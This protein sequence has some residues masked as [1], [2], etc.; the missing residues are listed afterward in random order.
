MSQIVEFETLPGARYQQYVFKLRAL[1]GFLGGPTGT[2]FKKLRDFMRQNGI[3]DKERSA[4]AM[5][6]LE[7]TWDRKTVTLGPTAKRLLDAASEEDFKE[8]LFKRLKLTNILLVKYVLE[9]LDV[10]SGG[11]LHSVNEL[12]RMITSYVYPGEYVTLTN[13][14]AWIE[15]MAASEVIKM[16]GIRWALGDPRGTSAVEELK[17]MDIEE[18]LEDLEEEA[19]EAEEASTARAT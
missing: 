19:E 3:W 12:Y 11:R 13:F 18:I 7:I 6:F 14:K 4:T 16:V 2:E 8:I 9:A 17:A 1:F 5:A 15:W 10:D